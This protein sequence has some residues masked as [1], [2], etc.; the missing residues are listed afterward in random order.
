M[1]ITIRV[2]VVANRI[3][4]SV[5]NSPLEILQILGMRAL[6]VVIVLIARIA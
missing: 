5:R 6:A 3:A 1:S 4:M 2:V